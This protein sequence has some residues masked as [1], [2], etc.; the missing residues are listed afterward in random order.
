M[1]KEREAAAQE[2]QGTEGHAAVVTIDDAGTA[3][4]REPV[5]QNCRLHSWLAAATQRAVRSSVR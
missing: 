3:G 2:L 4:E 1:D 5:V